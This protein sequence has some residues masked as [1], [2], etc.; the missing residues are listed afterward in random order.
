[1]GFL[2]AQLRGILLKKQKKCCF[3]LLIFWFED[4]KPVPQ[5]APLPDRVGKK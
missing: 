1:M 2:K 4:L 3:V 5:N